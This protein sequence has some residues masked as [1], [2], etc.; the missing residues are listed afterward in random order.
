MNGVGEIERIVLVNAELVS[1]VEV[2]YSKLCFVRDYV[3]GQS[4][5]VSLGCRIVSRLTCD[6]NR[7]SFRHRVSLRAIRESRL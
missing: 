7:S 1:K 2:E 3:H 6:C 4:E 5:P